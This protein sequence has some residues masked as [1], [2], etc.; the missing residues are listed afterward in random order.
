[1]L[2]SLVTYQ[3]VV[4]SIS[5]TIFPTALLLFRRSNPSWTASFVN[6]NFFA[7]TGLI[8]LLSAK[9]KCKQS[10]HLSFIDLQLDGNLERWFK[11]DTFFSIIIKCW[12]FL[13]PIVNVLKTINIWAFWRWNLVITTY[14]TNLPQPHGW[15]SVNCYILTTRF[16]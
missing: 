4:G 3:D 8:R 15:A 13:C 14:N 11:S 6:G 2:C 9:L 10:V 16:Q 5:N 12:F 1:M 7:K